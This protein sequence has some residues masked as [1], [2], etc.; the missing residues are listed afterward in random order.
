MGS[1]PGDFKEV[2]QARVL[3][4]DSRLPRSLYR[5]CRLTEDAERLGGAKFPGFYQPVPASVRFVVDH[6]ACRIGIEPRHGF[7]DPLGEWH[8]GTVVRD[9][10]LELGVVEDYT[11]RLVANKAALQIGD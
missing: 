3:A 9:K 5:G 10:A 8:R 1:C 2:S 6:A 11:D 4:S 7:T